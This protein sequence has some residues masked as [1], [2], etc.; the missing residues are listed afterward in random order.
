MS[1]PVT[2]YSSLVTRYSSL[3][4]PP[5][6]LSTHLT[7]LEAS[8]LIRLA[9]I[10]PELEYL[11]RHALLQEAAYETLLKTER[12]RLHRE[13]GETLERLY[14]ERL[15]ELA[16]VLAGHFD[17]GGDEQRALK[18]FTLA[19]DA[20]ARVYANAE[21]A[22]HYARA[23]EIARRLPG[24]EGT[25]FI[26]LYSRRGHAL[27]Q[28]SCHAEAAANYADLESLARERGDQ[29]M[30]FAAL[31]TRAKI[32]STPNP[33]QNPAQARVLLEQALS[34]AR[35]LDDRAAECR[36]LWNFMLLLVWSGGD[37]RQAVA[38]GEAA[39]AL[40]RE[41]NLRE[42]LAFTLND[43]TY[44]YIAVNEWARAWETV[45]EA[46]ALWRELDTRPML[47]DSLSLAS[48][49]YLRAGHY[50]RALTAVHEALA[51]SQ[52]IGNRW[53][54]VSSLVY[55]SYAYF[56]R[57]EI[58][59]AIQVMEEAIRLGGQIG[60][61][62]GRIVPA[63]DLGW[64]YGTLGAVERGLASARQAQAWSANERLPLL[65]AYPHLILA[66]LHVLA[67]DLPAAEAALEEGHRELKPE[68]VQMFS[69]IFL[70]LADGELALAKRDY[71]RAIQTVDQLLAHLE[72]TQTRAFIPDALYL[73]GQALSALERIDEACEVLSQARA[74]AETLGSR[75]LLWPTLAALAEIEAG[76]GNTSEAQRYRQHARE[77]I[78]YIAD[79]C[80]PDP[81]ALPAVA[82]QSLRDS[83]LGLSSVRKALDLR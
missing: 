58:D 19:G 53:G 51:I 83:F 48:I 65:R 35:A 68:G 8:G 77:V 3:V 39:L 81:S 11:F 66:R 74:K 71:A 69:P 67:D 30:V 36:V 18:Y 79:H 52:G 13:V 31:M 37:Q 2:C 41:L 7:T 29:A 62:F 21:A 55:G 63:A 16:P 57:G 64:A 10:E 46:I 42:Q 4:T 54:Q 61:A 34:L 49:I 82:G 47:S 14:P 1:A 9:Q 20:A 32:Y 70:A 73:K 17:Q 43:L 38:Y 12:K 26:H 76:R 59:Q 33:V 45:E 5:L 78:A 40:A 44:A 75:R 27:E 23:L 72:T 6:S 50:E 22:L 15:E 80:P 24:V 60:L 28:N 25:Q 56:E